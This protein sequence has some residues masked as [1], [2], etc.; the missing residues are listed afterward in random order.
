MLPNLV[1]RRADIHIPDQKKYPK[2]LERDIL[3][4]NLAF[5]LKSNRVARL[6]LVVHVLEIWMTKQEDFAR[7]VNNLPYGFRISILNICSNPEDMELRV[8]QDFGVERQLL[9]VKSFNSMWKLPTDAW[10]EKLKLNQ[11]QHHAQLHDTVS[12]NLVLKIGK[13]F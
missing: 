5:C 9:S 4:S 1:Y 12:L 13:I 8:I 2:E 10:P 6:G 3:E 7:T 11:F